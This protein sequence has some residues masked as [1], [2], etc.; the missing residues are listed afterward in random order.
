M[1]TPPRLLM[2]EEEFLAK[3]A[4]ALP[5]YEFVNGEVTQK[6]MT[7]RSHS[8]L[9]RRLSARLDAYIERAG[10]TGGPEPTVDLS[11]ATA[12]R[13]RVPDVAYWSR[14][15]DTGAAVLGAP[16]LSVEIISEGQTR[17]ELREKCRLFRAAGAEICW[18]VDPNRRTV[19]VFDDARDGE[20]QPETAVLES[21]HMPG[22]RLALADLFAVLDA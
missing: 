13:Y 3:Y 8:A 22:F 17:A 9:A 2:T 16:T 11:S 5:S 21:P 12:R 1:T 7:K 10:G 18:L 19:E 6:P 15:K 14:E 20:V 4:D